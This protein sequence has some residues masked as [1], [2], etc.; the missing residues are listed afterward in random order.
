MYELPDRTLRDNLLWLS[1]LE[2]AT[3]VEETVEETTRA[4]H[5]V[6]AEY[7]LLSIYQDAEPKGESYTKT[8]SY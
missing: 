8:V 2:T 1:R 4:F 6:A 3:A 7:I 5:T